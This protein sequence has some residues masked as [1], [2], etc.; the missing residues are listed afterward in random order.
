MGRAE[1]GETNSE[2]ITVIDNF[3]PDDKAFTKKNRSSALSNTNKN[4]TTNRPDVGLG[5]LPF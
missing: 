3:L 1:A 4:F 5:Y 2:E